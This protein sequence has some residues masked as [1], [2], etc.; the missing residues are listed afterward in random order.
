M[1]CISFTNLPVK[2]QLESVFAYYCGWLCV[3]GMKFFKPATNSIRYTI[4]VK[5]NSIIFHPGYY[6]EFPCCAEAAFTKK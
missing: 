6:S 2:E 4:D 1:D 5:N 3:I